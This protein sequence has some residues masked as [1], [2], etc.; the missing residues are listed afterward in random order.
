MAGADIHVVQLNGRTVVKFVAE[1]S[2]AD[3]HA[4]NQSCFTPLH[5]ACAFGKLGSCQIHAAK[6]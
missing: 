5:E 4:V 2:G 3:I 6:E 1:Q